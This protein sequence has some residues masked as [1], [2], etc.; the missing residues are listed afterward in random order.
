M[1]GKV[2][3]ESFV[4]QA[5]ADGHAKGG[6]LKV[7]Q[8]VQEMKDPA[9][10]DW[11]QKGNQAKTFLEHI[12]FTGADNVTRPQLAESWSASD[13]L[14][15]W[16]FKLRKGVK[17]SNGD[18]FGADD[19]VYNLERWLDPET[20]SSNVGLFSAM[21]EEVDTGKKD[22]DG[23]KMMSKRMIGGAVEK[24]DGHTVRMHL[25]RPVLSIPENFS[26]YPT[27]IV[28]RKFDDMGR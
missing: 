23:K 15:T 16:T 3:G 1:L 12:A 20:G 24:V 5:K 21:V 27:A 2:T 26:N 11:T 14:K 7:S 28:H 18:D 13:D 10:Y 25:N 22:K 19:M 6:H 8:R 17:W 9:T 4:P